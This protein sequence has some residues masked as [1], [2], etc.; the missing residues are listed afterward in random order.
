MS[1]KKSVLLTQ[2][3][4]SA[5]GSAIGALADEVDALQSDSKKTLLVQATI[6]TKQ[7]AIL[8]QLLGMSETLRGDDGL[9]VKTAL[10]KTRLD[11]IEASLVE[12]KVQVNINK[13]HTFAQTG[14]VLAIA[15]IAIT[16]FFQVPG[17]RRLL[18]PD[19]LTTK[20]VAP[21]KQ[22]PQN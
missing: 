14:S 3:E 12:G 22:P 1:G 18:E 20:D 9:V 13:S 15:T 16:L 17:C 10:L 11:G 7:E 2:A 21:N 8:Q 6:E 19:R 5:L 4:I